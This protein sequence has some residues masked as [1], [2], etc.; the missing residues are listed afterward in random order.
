MGA[1][2]YNPLAASSARKAHMRSQ[3]NAGLAHDREALRFKGLCC[4]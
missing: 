3:K 1:M 2:A 4:A